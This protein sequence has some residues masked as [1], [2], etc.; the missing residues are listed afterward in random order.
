MLRVLL[1]P[2]R[3]AWMTGLARTPATMVPMTVTRPPSY[4]P[5]LIEQET[6]TGTAGSSVRR[7][8]LPDQWLRGLLAGAEALIL[9]WLV[10]VVPAVATYVATA[11]SPALGSAGW[12]E[13][14]QVG[15]AGWFLAHGAALRFGEG[16]I[17]VVPLGMTL[18]C[19]FL[20]SMSVRRARLARWVPILTAVGTYTALAALLVLFV[21][22]PGAWQGLIGAAGVAALGA[23]WGMRGHYPVLPVALADRLR[24]WPLWARTGWRGMWRLSVLILGVAV[25]A[26]ITALILGFGQIVEVQT[27]L[28][29][30]PVSTVV[31]V[32]AQLLL[33]PVLAVWALAYLLG[34]GF[35]VGAETLFSP[36]GIESGPLPLVPVLGALPEPGS[37]AGDL[38]FLVVVGIAA[39]L[40]G[41][42][43]IARRTRETSLPRALGAAG[44]AVLGTV[45]LVTVLGWLAS[46]GIGPGGMAH[47]GPDPVQLAMA[48]LWQLGG[49]VLAVVLA[50]HPSSHDGVRWA[51][52]KV[53]A[54]AKN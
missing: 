8:R 21:D 32:G 15:T 14:A 42:W 28:G 1:H 5:R 38:P 26:L 10:L 44:I 4:Q 39:G 43:W 37:L 11:A 23:L 17:S 25:A 6:T 12:I 48:A 22:A 29:A 9:G 33:L 19:A 31:I 45:A 53:R 41:G 51:V 35:S 40:A 36:G 20:V 54:V 50:W 13:A 30:D 7:V 34:P 24:S 3:R 18:L 47:L 49:G 52:G 2:T 46:G 27:S 16:A